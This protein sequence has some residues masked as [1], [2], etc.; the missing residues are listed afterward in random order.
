MRQNTF[1]ALGELQRPHIQAGFWGGKEIWNGAT[2]KGYGGKGKWRIRK[3]KK[4]GGEE[5][6]GK[7]RK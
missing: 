1:A 2:K 7:R 4:K 5:G 6:S 3:G